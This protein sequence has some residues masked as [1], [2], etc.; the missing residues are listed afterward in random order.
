MYIHHTEIVDTFAEAFK[1]WAA[2]VII[3]AET[4]QWA[5][6]A[7]Q[8]ITGFATSI[9]G[10]K[11]EAGIEAQLSPEETLDGRPGVSVL[12]F[13]V[14]A[15]DMGK[16]LLE[17]IGQCVLTC[18]TTACFDGLQAEQSVVVGGQLRFFGDGYQISKV[19]NGRRFW[20]IPVMEGEFLVDERF[21]V[22]PA[23]GG[24]NILILGRDVPATLRAT[25]A[26]VA[27]MRTVRGVIL[28]FP[29]GV[30]RSGSKTRSRY[31][32]LFA[33]T[34][35]AFCPTLRGIARETQVP[36]EAGCVLEIV[37]DGLDLPAVEEATRRGIIAAAETGDAMQIS[38]G[39]YGGTLG[40]YQ[41]RL[42]SVMNGKVKTSE[43]LETSEV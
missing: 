8:S 29:G 37:I 13:T 4:P 21:S 11:C 16:R 15:E 20:R 19:L 34:N 39:N 23:I 6:N 31:K 17:R 28:P 30:V 25:E 27:A 7:A 32:S 14:K 33:S 10:C 24:G 2:R 38:A 26:A 43:V 35:D 22:Q 18:P 1:M 41:I 3:T 12:F 42:H 9:I 5:M 40:Q 36:P